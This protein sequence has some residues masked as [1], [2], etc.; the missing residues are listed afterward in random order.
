MEWEICTKQSK[1]VN[2]K[3]IKYNKIK[4]FFKHFLIVHINIL[5][6]FIFGFMLSLIDY[7]F[8]NTN[9]GPRHNLHIDF[10]DSLF[11]V[12][13][14]IYALFLFLKKKIFDGMT[15][16]LMFLYF[17]SFFVFLNSSNNII[18]GYLDWFRF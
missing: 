1:E 8:N 13:Y 15:M 10:I 5:L 6:Y 9:L 11:P 16:I 3:M 4:F 12:P 18:Q 2:L 17:I 7:H 14:L